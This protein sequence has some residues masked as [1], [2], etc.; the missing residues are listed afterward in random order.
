MN[1]QETYLFKL[2]QFVFSY[3]SISKPRK[4]VFAIAKIFMFASRNFEIIFRS[5][6]TKFST[7]LHG[8]I[9]HI[10]ACNSTRTRIRIDHA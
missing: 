2:F 5:K 9:H 3:L 10:R 1:S 6:N 8:S 4:I 7:D